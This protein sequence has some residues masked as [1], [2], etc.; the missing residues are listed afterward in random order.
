MSTEIREK[1]H[2]LHNPNKIFLG[3]Q[4][5]PA[6]ND[7]ILTIA[8]ANWEVVENPKLNTKEEER[9]IRFVEN[10]PWLKPFVCNV[11]NAKMI[12][13]V[14]GDKFIEDSIGK[15]LKI[16]ISQTKIM[17]ETVD[18]LRVRDVAQRD[19]TDY[20]NENQ[21][22][23]LMGLCLMAGKTEAEISSIMKI[24]GLRDLPSSKFDN[25]KKKLTLTINQNA[26]N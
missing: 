14:T 23:E 2:W 17:G 18:C 22:N 20:I 11:T 5:L 7:V 21:L 4:D 8:S 24:E 6:G 13:K 19:L 1:T 26:N 10:Y 25:V 12:I 9:I 15:K 3:H 16:G